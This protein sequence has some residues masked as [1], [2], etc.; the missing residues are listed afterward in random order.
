MTE[1]LSL[2]ALSR[3]RLLMAVPAVATA[4]LL[5]SAAPAVAQNAGDPRYGGD[6]TFLIDSLGNTWIPNNSAISSFQGHI[7]GHVTDKL[8]YVDADGKVSP[9]LAESWEQNEQATEFILR[10]KPGV[11]F[12]D[13][14]PLDASASS[15]TSTS[16]TPAAGRTASTRS[17]SSRR[18]MSA[19]QRS[20]PRR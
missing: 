8:V 10:L 7:W 3:R 14:T 19:P 2:L 15:P 12:S 18:P 1:R 17:V 6:I 13:G 20:I 11:T 5:T 16:G 9:W 4:A